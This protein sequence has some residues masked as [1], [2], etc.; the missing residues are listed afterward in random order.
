MDRLTD[1]TYGP[2]PSRRLGRSL[3]INNIPPK[4]CSYA[5]AYCQLGRTIK[6]QIERQKFYKPQLVFEMVK[7]R[8]ALIRQNGEDIDYLAFVPNGEPTLDINLGNIIELLKPLGIPIA[9]IT[10]GSLLDKPEVQRDLATAD[11]VSFKVDAVSETAWCKVD[12]PHRKLNL[13]AILEGMLAFSSSFNGKLVTETMLINGLNDSRESANEISQ[14]IAKLNPHL[15]YLSIPTRPPAERGILP[16]APKR[17]NQIYHIFSEFIGKVELLTGYEGNQFSATGDLKSEILSITSVH[18][19][20]R[21]ALDKL[22]EKN[23]AGTSILEELLIS[24][25]LIETEFSGCKY[26]L[27]NFNIH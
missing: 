25:E 2:V 26:Y 5:C 12:R 14:F 1:I 23:D 20:R 21:E 8:I 22:I 19:M 3:G 18:P 24:G 11:W 9:V 6:L 4:T 13:S 10:N 16:S 17:V 27:R 7:D 15:A